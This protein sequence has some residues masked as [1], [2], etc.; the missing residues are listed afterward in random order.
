M[1]AVS[2]L[3]GLVTLASPFASLWVLALVV[4]SWLIVI[5]LVEIVTALKIRG[6]SHKVAAALSAG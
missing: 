4:G 3:A 6:A 5:G 2:L 1:G